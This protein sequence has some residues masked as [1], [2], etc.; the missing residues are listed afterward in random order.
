MSLTNAERQA[1]HR[2][3]VAAGEPV[4]KF[5]RP[6][7]PRGRPAKWRAAIDT[8]T[9]L[10]DEYQAWRDRIPEALADGDMATR[11]DDLL[12]LRELVEQLEAAELPKGFGRD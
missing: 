7:G 3:K 1:R 9:E 11:L 4:T 5:K 12:A 8:L 6:A 2:A 10:L